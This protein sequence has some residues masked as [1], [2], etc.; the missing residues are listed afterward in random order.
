MDALPPLANIM[1]Y[2]NVRKTDADMV[3]HVVDGLVARIC[4]G[5]PGA[6]GGLNDEAAEELFNRILQV[7]AAIILLQN[8]EHSASWNAVLLQ[9]ADGQNQHGL[10]AGRAIRLLLDSKRI[11]TNDA[12]ARFSRALSIANAPA[13]ASAWV[14]GFLRNSG[15]LLLHDEA[16]WRVLDEWII[17]LSNDHFT[18]TLPLLRRTFSTFQHGERRQLG[19]RVASGQTR[20]KLPSQTEAGFD[21]TRANKVLPLVAQLLGLTP[22]SI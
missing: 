13:Q 12:E 22:P 16:L 15:L 1:R 8:A 5:L 9:L 11:E 19:V 2:G 3:S 4:I 7:N 20:Q 14:D 18:A 21:E 17:S 10:I 6:A